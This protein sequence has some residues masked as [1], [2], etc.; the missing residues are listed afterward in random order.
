MEVYK[1]IHIYVCMYIY[2]CVCVCVC[3]CV[4]THIQKAPEW[5]YSGIYKIRQ[6]KF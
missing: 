1:E 2:V 6:N 4:Y 5:L 3:V